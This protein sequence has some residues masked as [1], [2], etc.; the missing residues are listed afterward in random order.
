[1]RLRLVLVPVVRLIVQ[2]ARPYRRTSMSPDEAVAAASIADCFV[3][4]HAETG[5]VL[6]IRPTATGPDGL[7]PALDEMARHVPTMGRFY[8]AGALTL[9][10]L[11]QRGEYFRRVT[12]RG[13]Q[14]PELEMKPA[15]EL[16]AMLEG[17]V[18]LPSALGFPFDAGWM[19]H[20]IFELHRDEV[21][22][23]LSARLSHL[24]WHFPAES[25][26][27]QVHLADVAA[28]RAALQRIWPALTSMVSHPDL[29]WALTSMVS[30]P[31]IARGL[32]PTGGGRDALCRLGDRAAGLRR[33]VGG[34]VPRG[35]GARAGRLS[36]RVSRCRPHPRTG[37]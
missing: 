5:E 2:G 12:L 25:L 20:A 9:R 7:P 26:A 10:E 1:M 21:D 37:A 35:L 34:L 31:F 22:A 33:A 17:S 15:R 8:R 6:S 30:D 4:F 19:I 28:D 3:V 18:P 13:R 29:A 32:W 16:V 24:R 11:K 23:D 14:I 36:C 27:L